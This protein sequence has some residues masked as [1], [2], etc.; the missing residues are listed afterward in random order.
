MCN[1]ISELEERIKRDIGSKNKKYE[2]MVIKDV[3]CSGSALV[4]N[5]NKL[6]LITVIPFHVHHEPIGR[7]MKTEILMTA[8][9]C[10]FCGKKYGEE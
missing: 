6:E 1:C 10:P 9:Y 3:E 4:E 2:K 8:K 7:K 5:D